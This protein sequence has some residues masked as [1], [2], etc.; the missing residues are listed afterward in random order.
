MPLVGSPRR[1][2]GR[3][4]SASRLSPARP[5]HPASVVAPPRGRLRKEAAKAKAEAVAAR[6]RGLQRI[7]SG[8]KQR[9]RPPS[10]TPLLLCARQREGRVS[11]WGCGCGLQ[12]G[13]GR[14]FFRLR[15]SH[16]LGHTWMAPRAPTPTRIRSSASHHPVAPLNRSSAVGMIRSEV[17]ALLELEYTLPILQSR[18][19]KILRINLLQKGPQLSGRAFDCRSNGHRFKSGWALSVSQFLATLINIKLRILFESQ[20]IVILLDKNIIINSIYR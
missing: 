1:E 20:S 12:R 13:F 18:Y 2:W 7:P 14:V 10:A 19:K 6:R 9:S 8:R 16:C 11:G 5:S 3:G 15:A 17:F 4:D